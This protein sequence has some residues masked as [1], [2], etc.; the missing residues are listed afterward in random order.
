RA[1]L[2][3]AFTEAGII[4]P[5][6]EAFLRT[7][8]GAQMKQALADLRLATGCQPDL[9]ERYVTLYWLNA[10]GRDPVR[11][12]PTACPERSRREPRSS[13]SPRSGERVGERGARV[14]LYPGVGN[15]LRS[16]RK[17]VAAMG[18]VTQ[19]QRAFHLEGRPSGAQAELL[20]LGI[21]AHFATV[22][23]FEDVANH[24]PHPEPILLALERLGADPRTTLVVGDS[25]ADIESGRA[26]GCLTC[27]ASWGAPPFPDGVEAHSSPR[28]SA[29]ISGAALSPR[30]VAPIPIGAGEGLS[31]PFPPREGAGVRLVPDFV[32]SAPEALLNIVAGRA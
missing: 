3:A 21:D 17:R 10:T 23:G 1:A 25:V 20:E 4:D 12:E 15:M 28:P 16:L 30:R 14:R 31:Y 7:M 27:F 6:A 13:P 5:E 32:A 22:V 9:F 24:K 19:K 29:G 26:A 2:H 8:A 18:I 11:G